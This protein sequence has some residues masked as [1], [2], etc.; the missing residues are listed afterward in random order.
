M[1]R[2]RSRP[3]Q[4]RSKPPTILERL[5]Q[6][7]KLAI[8]IG[9]IVTLIA[10]ILGLVA[11]FFPDA[12]P[13]PRAPTDAH[14]EILDFQRHVTL[15]DYLRMINE[16]DAKYTTQQLKRDG[17]VATV[18]AVQVSGMKR[19]DLYST[20]RDSA[21]G[22]NLSDDH[23]VHR[24]V[25]YF[26]IRTTGDSGGS[27]FWVEAPRQPGG[28]FVYFQLEAPNETILASKK[29]AQFIVG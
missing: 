26:K 20:V 24:R 18:K 2:R 8:S 1:T 25:G 7:P 11:W 17:V 4:S 12:K 15:G 10:G 3:R 27:P 6:A 16:K 19:A 13:K 9:A 28:Y 5:K 23:Y 22:S 14:I 29:T 21:S